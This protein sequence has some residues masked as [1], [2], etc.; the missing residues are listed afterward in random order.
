MNTWY[1]LCCWLS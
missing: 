1:M